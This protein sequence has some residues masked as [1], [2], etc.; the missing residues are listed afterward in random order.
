M[1]LKLILLALGVLVAGAV[2]AELRIVITEGVARAVPIAVVPFG[3]S[4]GGS[5]PLDVAGVVAADLQRSGR[6]APM[7]R[8]D[9]LERPITGNEVDFEDWRL[10][11]TDVIVIGQLIPE[12]DDTYTIQFQVF[13]VFRGE[14]L[15]GFQL[16]STSAA[17]RASAHKVSDMIFEELTGIPGAFSTRIAY[18][19]VE[20]E[21]SSRRYKLIV[22][23]ADGENPSTI[24]ESPASILSPAWSPDGRRLAYVSF[25]GDASS[26]YVQTLRTGERLRVSAHAGVNGAPAF[27]PDGRRLAM[28]LSDPD[29]NLDIW[30]MEL[31]SREL[32]RLT[33]SPAIDTEADWSADGDSLVFTSDRSGGPQIY[34]VR[35]RGG[36]AK[37]VTFEGNYN[38]RARQSPTA[39]QIAVVHNDRGSYRIA[40]VDPGRNTL[41]VLTDGRLDESPSFAPNGNTIIY[42]TRED[43]QAVLATVSV[44]GQVRQRIASDEGDVREPVWSPFPP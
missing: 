26:I 11:G 34:R 37:R 38:A 3:W 39:D 24:A 28:T 29:G 8:D 25:E 36:Q 4:A 20:G 30:V 27:S 18:V 23:D 42:A 9:M 15:L 31:A 7:D 44:D 43:G 2:Q 12:A 21:G 1:H 40:L 16:P 33:D 22:A 41:Q 32:R 14:Q 19:S 13:D 10:L 17:L 35:A 6:F 5:A